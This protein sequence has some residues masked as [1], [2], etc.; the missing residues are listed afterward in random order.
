MD[1]ICSPG[2]LAGRSGPV[3]FGT[4]FYGP[5]SFEKS[6]TIESIDPIHWA[7]ESLIGKQLGVEG[8]PLT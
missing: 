1:S 6:G 3:P 7:I 5:S 2:P 8:A 4:P